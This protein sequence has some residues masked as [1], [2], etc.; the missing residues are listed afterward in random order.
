MRRYNLHVLG[1]SESRWTDSGR[2]TTTSGETALYSGR[3]DRQHHERVAIIF[4]KR[5]RE[6]SDG[7]EPSEQQIDY[8]KTQRK[9]SKY[10]TIPMLYY[11]K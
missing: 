3:K 8:S 7:M 4:K 6:V 11:S 2:I 10:I 9:T 5:S 1:I